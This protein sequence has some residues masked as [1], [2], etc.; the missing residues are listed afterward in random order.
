MLG[1]NFP[2]LYDITRLKK[3]EARATITIARG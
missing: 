1:V 2:E 3:G